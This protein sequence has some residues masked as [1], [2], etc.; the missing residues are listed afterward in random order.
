[1]VTEP[2]IPGRMIICDRNNSTTITSFS[3]YFDS[4]YMSGGYLLNSF[5]SIRTKWWMF[6]HIM[7]MDE[8]LRSLLD[9]RRA[10]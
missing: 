1:M 8:L 7:S 5:S 4:S 2:M 9:S 6:S 3:F 10:A